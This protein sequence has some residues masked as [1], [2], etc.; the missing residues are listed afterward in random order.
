ME[1]VAFDDSEMA[2]N[3]LRIERLAANILFVLFDTVPTKI[4]I[5]APSESRT[6]AIVNHEIPLRQLEN[7]IGKITDSV[8]KLEAAHFRNMEKRVLNISNLQKAIAKQIGKTQLSPSEFGIQLIQSPK[9]FQ[10]VNDDVLIPKSREVLSETV[11]DKQL[12]FNKLFQ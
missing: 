10:L 6:L 3:T 1:V 12:I 2:A 7:E 11:L 5:K 4:E 9:A 8:F